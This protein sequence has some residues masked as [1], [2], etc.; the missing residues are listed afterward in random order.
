MIVI[1][2]FFA[3]GDIHW[4]VVSI[5]EVFGLNGVLTNLMSC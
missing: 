1:A 3:Q 5:I 2:V 4:K